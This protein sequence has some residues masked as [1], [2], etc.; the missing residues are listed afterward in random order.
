M[1]LAHLRRNT[2]VGSLGYAQLED[3]PGYGVAYRILRDSL[4]RDRQ[5]SRMTPQAYSRL[6]VRADERSG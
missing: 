4:E 3:D 6:Q 1:C 2:E 5:L